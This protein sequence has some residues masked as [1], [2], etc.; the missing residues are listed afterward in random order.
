[1]PNHFRLQRRRLSLTYGTVYSLVVA[2]EVALL[3]VSR[4]HVSGWIYA[5]IVLFTVAF[6]IGAIRAFRMA[7]IKA[8]RTASRSEASLG[9]AACGGVR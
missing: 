3:T 9:L 4:G 2:G 5:L 6:L 8:T 7:T 1:M